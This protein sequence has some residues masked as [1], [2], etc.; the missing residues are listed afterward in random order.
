[1]HVNPFFCV[2]CEHDVYMSVCIVYVC[3]C[4]CMHVYVCELYFCMCGYIR[5]HLHVCELYVSMC[6][7]I[8]TNLHVNACI[9]RVGD[10]LSVPTLEALTTN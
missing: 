8:C 2:S 9:W 1:V 4:V 5:T 7:Y 6:V 3:M 10:I